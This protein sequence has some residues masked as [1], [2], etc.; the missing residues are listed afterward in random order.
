MTETTENTES[1]DVA[2]TGEGEIVP[3][4]QPMPEI[5]TFKEEAAEFDRFKAECLG[6]NEDWGKVPNVPKPFLWKSGAE[7]IARYYGL[8]PEYEIMHSDERWEMEPPLVVY[9]VRCN[10]RHVATNRLISAGVGHANSR[11]KKWRYRWVQ[12]K[13]EDNKDLADQANTIIKIAKKRA[14]VDAILTAAPGASRHFTQDPQA[15]GA[16]EDGIEEGEFEEVDDSMNERGGK[17]INYPSEPEPP[18]DDSAAM[19]PEQ[20][21]IN[22]R[23]DKMYE[24]EELYGYKSN[25]LLACLHEIDAEVSNPREFKTVAQLEAFIELVKKQGGPT[26]QAAQLKTGDKC[27]KCGGG[28]MVER[29]GSRGPFLGCSTYPN[30][31]NTCDLPKE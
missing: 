3:A 5:E 23:L 26:A 22:A 2:V 20:D 27:P 1:K 21:Q 28:K 14:Y 29:T 13:R 8:V 19:P 15:V 25:V 6:E 11:E 24:Q 10:L 18:A 12:G 7:K 30:C 17:T 31:K 9:S 4:G 16:K